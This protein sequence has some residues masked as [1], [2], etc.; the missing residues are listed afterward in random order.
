M[1]Q[2]GDSSQ[3]IDPA[4]TA[5]LLLHWQN[6]VVMSGGKRSDKLH[7]R[8]KDS[9]TIERTQSVLAV[10]R[11]KGILLIYVNLCHRHGYPERSP[12]SFNLNESY[13]KLN[14]W[15]EGGWG[16]EN[17]DQLKPLKNEIIVINYSPSAFCYT[18]LD[19]ILRNQG[20]TDLVLSGIATNWVVENT[21]REGANRGYYIFTIKDCCNSFNDEMHSWPFMHIFPKLGSVLDSA[22]YI[23]TLNRIP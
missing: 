18:E 4:K 2:S 14:A 10:T 21:A 12:V 23:E 9:Q 6:E 17:I 5:L 1:T 3:V 15:L 16:V 11:E 22:T 8:I 7:A 20:I 13:T 19:L